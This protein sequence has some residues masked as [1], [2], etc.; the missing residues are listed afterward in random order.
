M[1]VE[2]T[3]K[4]VCFG[5]VLWDI[6]PDSTALPGGAPMNVAYHLHKMEL[7]PALITRVG[8]DEPG[9]A[10]VNIFKGH[11]VHTG[12]FQYD[13]QY[14]TGKVYAHPGAHNEMHYE[15]VQPAAWDFIEPEPR[16]AELIRQAE[17]FV[18]GSLACRSEVSRHTLFLLLEQAKTKVLDINLRAPHYQTAL[19]E[20][21]LQKSDIL[22]LNDNELEI[23]CAE[24]SNLHTLRDRV[25]YI[26]NR[27][28]I[29]LVVVT[30]GENGALLCAE[31]KFYPVAGAAVA[32]RDTIGCGDAFLAALLSRLLKGDDYAKALQFANTLGAFIAT[33]QGGCPAYSLHDIPFTLP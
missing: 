1:P 19:L 26:M 24:Q 4:V 8:K 15:I 12:Y 17:Y 2:P 6:L 22:K 9:A 23:L 3:H 14:A 13:A 21:L 32:V 5:E 31:E 33:K 16:H 25:L 28:S 27:F 11:G 7:Y 10:L 30:M 20:E 18:F 29:P